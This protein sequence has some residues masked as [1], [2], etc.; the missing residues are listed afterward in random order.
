VPAIDDR[1]R[2]IADRRCRGI[3][4]ASLGAISALQMGLAH[5]ERFGLVLAFSPV[6]ADPAIAGYLAAA[7]TTARLDL[8]VD[9]DDDPIGRADRA[10]LAAI[11]STAPDPARHTALV[12]T[13]GGR[14]A[15]ASWAQRVVPALQHLLAAPCSG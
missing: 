7:W 13:P 2:T 4:G 5:P 3:G 8:L 15:I 1:F 14:H 11:V 12:Q 6:L 10:W 9:F